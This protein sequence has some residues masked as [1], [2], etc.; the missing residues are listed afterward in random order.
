RRWRRGRRASRWR[1][2]PQLLGQLDLHARARLLVL[3]CHLLPDQLPLMLAE[4]AQPGEED[5]LARA[6]R[7]LVDRALLERDLQLEELLLHGLLAI[8]LDL[9]DLD[10]LLDAVADARGRKGE[11]Q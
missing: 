11:G 5:G 7:A 6:V 10:H 8:G 2:S 9:R 3:L 4:L 1:W